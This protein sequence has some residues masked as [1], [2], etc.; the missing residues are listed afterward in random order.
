MTNSEGA[1]VD[2]ASDQLGVLSPIGV[3]DV[4]GLAKLK[5]EGKQLVISEGSGKVWATNSKM[6]WDTRSSWESV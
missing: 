5:A 3:L 6:G 4:R 2:G 1:V